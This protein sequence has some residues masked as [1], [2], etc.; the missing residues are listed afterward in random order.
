M[1]ATALSEKVDVLIKGGMTGKAIA[2]KAGCDS[3]TI[4]RI[5]SG[6]ISDPNYSIGSTI[7]QLYAEHQ[8]TQASAA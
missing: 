5:R 1:S 2:E 4:S 8:Q 3:S 6:F 7:D